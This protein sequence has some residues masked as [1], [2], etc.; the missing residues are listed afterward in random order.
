MKS[1]YLYFYITY[2]RIF[3][4]MIYYLHRKNLKNGQME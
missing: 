4:T 2:I 3:Q 1:V